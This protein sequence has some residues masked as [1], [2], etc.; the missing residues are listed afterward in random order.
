[1]VGITERNKHKQG[2]ISVGFS[3]GWIDQDRPKVTLYRHKASYNAEGCMSEDIGT[4]VRGVPGE[5]GYVLSKAKIGLFP[6]APGESCKCQ[7]CSVSKTQV[8]V[9]T[10]ED[11]GEP[12]LSE[13]VEDKGAREDEVKRRFESAVGKRHR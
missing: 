8:V 11:R 6:W 12:V 7:W 1:M 2:L 4:T 10:V 3:L 9:E 13:A 5:H